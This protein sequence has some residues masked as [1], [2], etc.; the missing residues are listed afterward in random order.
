M[1]KNKRKNNDLQ[2]RKQKTKDW[3][4]RIIK[5]NVNIWSVAVVNW[6]IKP[7]R[8]DI[9]HFI[10]CSMLYYVIIIEHI[11]SNSNFIGQLHLRVRVNFTLYLVGNCVRIFICN[12][13]H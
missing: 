5:K 7:F 13:T 3:V 9:K 6:V 1:A 11:N 2:N 12:E 10:K 4:W 8:L